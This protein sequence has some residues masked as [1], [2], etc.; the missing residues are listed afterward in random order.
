MSEFAS[1]P[2]Y[3]LT[4]DVVRSLSTWLIGLVASPIGIIVLAALDSTIF[5]S[6]PGGIDA[7]VLLLAAQRHSLAWVVALLA[8]AGSVGGAVLT[9]W[10]GVK[11]GAHGIDRYVSP[12]RLKRVRRTIGSVGAIGMAAL[13]LIPPPFPFTPFILAAGAL[14]V[15][16]ATFF[17]TLTACC[18]L[19]V[20]GEALLAVI[21]GHQILVWFDSDAVHDIVVGFSVLA[22]ALTMVSIAN[23][24][25]S[26]RRATH[27][28]AT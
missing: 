1:H 26:S 8:T 22:V 3:G 9:F 19:R 12:K 5:F 6:A 25:T 16:A 27:T 18:V 13:D 17:G 10:M 14:E 21:Y 15:D 28:A 11:I 20:G 7:A 4:T 24:F 2:V 23:V